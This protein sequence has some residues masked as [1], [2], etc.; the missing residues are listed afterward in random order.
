MAPHGAAVAAERKRQQLQQQEEEEEVTP[1]GPDPSG[2]FEY[3][4][5]R[6]STAA[7]KNPAKL[8]AFLEVEAR[9]GWELL[10]KL[11]D[12]RVRLKR[13]IAWRQQDNDL[14][15]D[16]Y[17]TKVGVTEGMIAVWAILVALGVAALVGVVVLVAMQ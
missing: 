12:S 6:S 8:R 16:P 13:N 1:L 17:R 15:Q 3:K 5:I 2:P 4:I 7:F 14:A 9:A 10:E 11:D